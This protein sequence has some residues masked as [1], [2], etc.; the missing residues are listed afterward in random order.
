MKEEEISSMTVGEIVAKDFRAASILKDLGIDFCCGGKKG[1]EETCAEKG[2]DPSVL[3]EKIIA[4][5]S[6]PEISTYN[7]NEWE[8]GFLCD[9]I[10]N[11]HHKY[12]LKSLPDLVFYTSKISDVHGDRH[13]ELREVKELFMEV[14]NELLK[15]LESEEKVFFPA[16]KEFMA[17]GS[18]SSKKIIES[19][20]EHLTAE[21]EFVGSAIDRINVLTKGYKVPEDGCN[22]Y[23]L[24]FRLL[25]QFEDD[26]HIHIHLE[27]NILIPKIIKALNN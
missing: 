5:E 7:Y 1:F 20:I 17:N 11:T 24:A 15:H 12:V 23:S 13:S 10:T 14:N 6:A 26:L 2:I 9:Y 21:H 18:Q 22:T 8:P 19:E 27:N 16:I 25:E 4:L 3:K